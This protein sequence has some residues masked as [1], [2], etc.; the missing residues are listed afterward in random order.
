M[1]NVEHSALLQGHRATKRRVVDS[2]VAREVDT[3]NRILGSCPNAGRNIDP[4]PDAP[5]DRG[6][7]GGRNVYLCCE[8]DVAVRFSDS[9]GI[10]QT[11]AK[12]AAA[13]LT[14]CVDDWSRN[15]MIHP[16]DLDVRHLLDT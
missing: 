5:E 10:E 15:L 16:V 3:A 4:L 11:R 7:I 1:S 12:T 8:I 6:T 2:A 9:P 14:L 13:K